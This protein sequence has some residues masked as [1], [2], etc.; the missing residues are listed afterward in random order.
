MT[1]VTPGPDGRSPD[2]FTFTGAPPP[3]AKPRRTAL[4]ITIAL[5]AVLA[6]GGGAF[7]IV[8]AMSGGGDQPAD[9]LPSTTAVYARV[10]I[11]PS[12]GQKLA[13]LELLDGLDPE[14]RETLESTDLREE[15][16]TSVTAGNPGLSGLDY[17]EDIAPWIGDRLGFGV[18]PSTDGAEPIV[19]VALQVTDEGAANDAIDTLVTNLGGAGSIDWFFSGD[20]VVFTEGQQA[21]TVEA[22]VEEGT[23]AD[24]ENFQSDQDDLGDQGI[25][26]FWADMDVITQE[27]GD[28]AAEIAGG[29]SPDAGG[30]V[31]ML[32]SG[33]SSPTGDVSAGRVAAAI[34]LGDNYVEVHGIANG[35][36]EAI[37]GG[38]SPQVILDLPDDTFAAMSVEHGDQ[39]VELFWNVFSEAAPDEAAQFQ[40]EGE[41]EGFSLPGDA[42]TLAGQS[43]VIS[44]G[45]NLVDQIMG[46][47]MGTGGGEAPD[48]AVRVSTEE[49]N[50]A[51]ELFTSL[52][53]GDQ[54]TEL[55][56]EVPFRVDDSIYTIG[57]NQAYVDAVAG[58][59]SLG[60]T[61][62]FNNAVP[63]AEGADMIGFV[64]LT[65]VSEDLAQQSGDDPQ[66]TS[67][68]RNL[69]AV[70]FSAE[71]DGTS[72]EFTLRLVGTD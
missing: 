48:F 63:G 23:L 30:V 36:M 46:M 65:T 38:D 57:G 11:D 32:A 16:F 20:Y 27:F 2:D 26:S 4:F 29:A 68:I 41:A 6:I 58:G 13:A 56:P 72:T 64:N 52:I 40:Q 17:E 34:R 47:N 7:A 60:D 14:I 18:I 61:D 49:A 43:A 53:G 28:E 21:A 8:R 69:G 55:P 67:V 10:D 62:L 22:M 15:F 50:R 59:G 66:I 9:A 1:A 71:V 35:H 44:A 24:S 3:S 33:A 51:Q 37:A 12:I 5:I 42:A 45:P 54:A 39:W 31:G 70:G 19:A 25:A